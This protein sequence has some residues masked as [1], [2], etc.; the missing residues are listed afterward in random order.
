[1]TEENTRSA[2]QQPIKTVPV[3]FSVDNTWRYTLRSYL[4]FVDVAQGHEYGPVDGS[5]AFLIAEHRTLVRKAEGG[6]LDYSSSNM[7]Q[8]KQRV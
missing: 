1:M 2:Y 4:H 6:L 8:L 7:E 5:K 3:S